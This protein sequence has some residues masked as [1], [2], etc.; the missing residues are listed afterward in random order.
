MRLLVTGGPDFADRDFLF[1]ILDRLHGAYGF[2]LVIHG[3]AAGTDRLAGRWA[4]R[5]GIQVLTCT[6]PSR[7]NG[8]QWMLQHS[9]NLVIAFPG[10]KDT[11]DMVRLGT[12]TGIEVVYINGKQELKGRVAWA[13][14]AVLIL[15]GQQIGS[16]SVLRCV[17]KRGSSPLW[18]CRCRCGTEGIVAAGNLRRGASLNCC[19]CGNTKRR[20]KT[21]THRGQSRTIFDWAADIG[22]RPDSLRARL[23]R[24]PL[25]IALRKSVPKAKPKGVQEKL[26]TFRGQT[27]NIAQWAK[28]LCLSRAGL[29]ARL[30]KT[31]VE[32]ALTM[33]VS[34]KARDAHRRAYQTRLSRG[35]FGSKAS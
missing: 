12:K 30:S 14:H 23:K 32:E 26:L 24:H 22:I 17:G 25:H 31:S 9:P 13:N 7:V 29:S 6:A 18:L 34:K 15:T 8:T 5:S 21:I 35:D 4:R 20:S 27:L 3:N 28:R 19:T 33:P 1:A 2:T 11:R 16:W 10:S